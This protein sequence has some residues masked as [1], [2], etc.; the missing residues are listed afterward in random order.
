MAPNRL[1]QRSH[2]TVVGLKRRVWIWRPYGRA[3]H[4]SRPQ[5]IY[6]QIRAVMAVRLP[7]CSCALAEPTHMHIELLLP[8]AYLASTA[9]H[10]C[11]RP[12]LA[13]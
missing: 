1:Y 8:L 12:A 5:E 10:A 2:V 11:R 4:I 3:P 6:L 9:N 13:G 7:L